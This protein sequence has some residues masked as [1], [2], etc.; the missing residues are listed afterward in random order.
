MIA[1]YI[2][3]STRVPYTSDA[4]VLLQLKYYYNNYYYYYDYIDTRRVVSVCYVIGVRT[5][6]NAGNTI[7]CA[8]RPVRATETISRRIPENENAAR[9]DR[10]DNDRMWSTSG[11]RCGRLDAKHL[12]ICRNRLARG[13]STGHLRLSTCLGYLDMCVRRSVYLNL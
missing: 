10:R 9:M 7:T 13:A 8:P 11:D 6:K 4:L 1:Y 5:G 3:T 12:L 2:R